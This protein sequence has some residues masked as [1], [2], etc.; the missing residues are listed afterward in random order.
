MLIEFAHPYIQAQIVF[1]LAVWVLS[2]DV[3]VYRVGIPTLRVGV[4]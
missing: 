3:K 1:V 2:L 4:E